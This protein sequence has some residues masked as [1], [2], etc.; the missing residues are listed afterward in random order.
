MKYIYLNI[1]IKNNSC[2]LKLI[3]LF[4]AVDYIAYYIIDFYLKF[5]FFLKI[6]VKR[7]IISVLIFYQNKL[8]ALNSEQKLF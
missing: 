2:N 8:A 3:K 6:A 1:L 5:K 7:K 4:L